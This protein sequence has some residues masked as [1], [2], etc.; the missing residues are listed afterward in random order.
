V[1]GKWQRIEQWTLAGACPVRD[2][3]RER[4]DLQVG[5]YVRDA[6][7]VRRLVERAVSGHDAV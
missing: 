6:V 4:V 7:N 5:L 3:G 2:L 1:P